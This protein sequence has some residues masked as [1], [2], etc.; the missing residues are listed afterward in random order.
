MGKKLTQDEYLKKRAEEKGIITPAD[1]PTIKE[2]G[3][4][5]SFADKIS[6]WQG[7]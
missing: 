2:Q 5:S 4:D 1:I 3:S 6:I 7:L